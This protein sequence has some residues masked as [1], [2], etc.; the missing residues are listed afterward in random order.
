M[1][2][3]DKRLDDYLKATRAMQ[4]GDFKHDIPLLIKDDVGELGKELKS[5]SITL[6]KRFNELNNIDYVVEKINKGLLVNEILEYVYES[7]SNI[8]PYDRI[9][10]SEIYSNGERLRAIWAKT[11][12]PVMLISKGFSAPLKGSSLEKIIKT[13]KPRIIND[14]KK[15]FIEHPHSESTKRVY[16]EGIR[17]SLTCPLIALNKSIGFIFFSSVETN[18]Y[19][20]IHI[21]TYQRLAGHLSIMLEKAKLYENLIEL[22]KVKNNFLGMAAHDLR[23]P[24][25]GVKGLLEILIKNDITVEEIKEMASIMHDACDNMLNL[26]N[27]LLDVTAI[28]SGTLKLNRVET[29]LKDFFDKSY[30]LNSTLAKSKNIELSFEVNSNLTTAVFDPQKLDQIINNLI[31]NAI[32]FSYPET[33]ITLRVT[34]SNGNLKI[35][36]SDQ[37]QGIPSKDQ[38]KIFQE[39]GRASVLPT[40]GEKSTG[41]GLAIVKK[42]VEAHRGTISVKSTVGK[43]STF[44]VIIPM[45]PEVTQ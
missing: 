13:G 33:K 6:E 1:K 19:N 32:K 39:F 42:M 26:I 35:D 18:I 28:E 16:E 27:E 30:T 10:F 44:T 41:L 31:T 34:E 17:S 4:E 2:K 3:H 37:G 24:L 11:S 9:G 14:L 8:I 25:S 23:S 43:G 29:V 5:L 12:L 7:F 45:Q 40:A 38:V 15:Y 22:N 20:D 21:E 36:V